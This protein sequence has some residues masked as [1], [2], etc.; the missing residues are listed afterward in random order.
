[1]QIEDPAPEMR[2][3]RNLGDAD[4]VQPV[5]ARIGIRLEKAAK[6]GEMRHQVR[7]RAVWGEA[8]PGRTRCRAAGRPVVCGIHP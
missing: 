1:V 3:A 6:A 2:P 7:S 5:I 4:A 8:I